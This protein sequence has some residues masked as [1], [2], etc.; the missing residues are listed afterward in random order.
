M[1]LQA[2]ISDSLAARLRERAASSGASVSATTAV[3]LDQAL[4][5]YPQGRRKAQRRPLIH[6]PVRRGE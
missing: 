1:R 5:R 4:S 3:L 6:V 2:T